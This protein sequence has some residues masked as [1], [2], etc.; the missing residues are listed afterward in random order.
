MLPSEEGTDQKSQQ[1]GAGEV[2][3]GKNL[4]SEIELEHEGGESL[5]KGRS[6]RRASER[7]ALQS[8]R[9]ERNFEG[10]ASAQE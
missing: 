3:L 10:G 7:Q 5:R 9:E 6:T 4:G 1:D 2:E 8:K